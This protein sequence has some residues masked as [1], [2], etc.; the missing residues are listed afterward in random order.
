MKYN[1]I[2]LDNLPFPDVIDET[3][4]STLGVDDVR[5]NGTTTV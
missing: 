5:F 1:I 3:F 2:D 4:I